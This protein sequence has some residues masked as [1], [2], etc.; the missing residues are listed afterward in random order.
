MS[1]I[2]P[3]SIIRVSLL[4]VAAAFLVAF[5]PSTAEA[6]QCENCLASDGT[7]E[8]CDPNDG[9]VGWPD[10]YTFF[11]L[12]GGSQ[13]CDIVGSLD[14]GLDGMKVGQMSQADLY[15]L[16]DLEVGPLATALLTETT[17]IGLRIPLGEAVS[18]KDC[19]GAAKGVLRTWNDVQRIRDVSS[20]FTL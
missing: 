8:A 17:K 12:C 5:S 4:G 6:Q 9:R 11:I 15:A 13:Y 19:S 3:S 18:V 14:I 7:F 1:R 2:Y 16:A 10:C 20:S